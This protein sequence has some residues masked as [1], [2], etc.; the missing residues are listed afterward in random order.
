M[1]PTPKCDD[2]PKRHQNHYLV[3]AKYDCFYNVL[4][5]QASSKMN[6]KRCRKSVQKLHIPG[7]Q[8]YVFG[9]F[10]VVPYLCKAL[11]SKMEPKRVSKIRSKMKSEM[12]PKWAP[13]VGVLISR[14]FAGLWSICGPL[15]GP[16]LYSCFDPFGNIYLAFVGSF[17]S[18]VL[19]PFCFLPPSLWYFL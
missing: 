9:V 16:F 4:P 3:H 10:L 11:G 15:L 7:H 5:A 8:K 1:G 12:I 14:N 19:I 2:S 6:T 18:V 13:K 17:L